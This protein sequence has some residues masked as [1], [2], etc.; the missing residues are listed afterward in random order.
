MPPR[1]VGDKPVPL[2][3]FELVFVLG[4]GAREEH[5]DGEYR[6]GDDGGER[7]Q[8]RLDDGGGHKGGE[9]EGDDE[10]DGGGGA[11]AV[12]GDEVLVDVCGDREAQPQ[13][14]VEGV[15]VE[16]RDPSEPRQVLRAEL[17]SDPGNGRVP[18]HKRQGR[19]GARADAA[20]G[21]AVRGAAARGGVEQ[22]RRRHGHLSRH[23]HA[24]R[25]GGVLEEAGRGG[26]GI[27]G[28]E[29]I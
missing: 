10:V 28:I 14:D 26:V 27:V 8:H 24:P 17:D 25:G 12:R 3:Y 13:L 2:N 21:R 16:H 9:E 29:G 4:R 11:D 18:R 23:D 19:V 1:A 5:A 22:E 6:R 7:L 20:R 15:S